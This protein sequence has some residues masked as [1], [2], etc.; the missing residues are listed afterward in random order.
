MVTDGQSWLWGHTITVLYFQKK[1]QG[2]QKSKLDMT[3]SIK[4]VPTHFFPKAK[5]I[6]SKRGYN[7]RLLFSGT[8]ISLLET[9]PLWGKSSLPN[10][11][12]LLC[13]EIGWC[14]LSWLAWIFKSNF[15]CFIRPYLEK[16][17]SKSL[18]KLG[19]GLMTSKSERQRTS[20]PQKRSKSDF[21]YCSQCYR[22]RSRKL[23]LPLSAT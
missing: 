14:G 21:I 8:F 4:I 9:Y 23:D 7:F 19:D 2:L 22:L 20:G 17:F 15:H 11:T 6:L 12:K 5:M 18:M 13:W 10:Q 1:W 16:L 3:Q